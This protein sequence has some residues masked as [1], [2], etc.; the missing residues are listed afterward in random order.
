MSEG[1]HGRANTRSSR[2]EAGSSHKTIRSVTIGKFVTL[3]LFFFN[4]KPAGRDG[5]TVGTLHIL[6]SSLK[7]FFSFR[8][9]YGKHS[10]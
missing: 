1:T 8:M 5:Q 10:I 2:W 9:F 6:A 3:F 4:L 7:I